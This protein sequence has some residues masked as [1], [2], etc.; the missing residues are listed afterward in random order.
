MASALE[1]DE[2]LC[3]GG[4]ATGA[5]EQRSMGVGSSDR[6][7]DDASVLMGSVKEEGGSLRPAL[8]SATSGAAWGAAG[9]GEGGAAS[10]SAHGACRSSETPDLG[11]GEA[12]VAVGAAAHGA[13]ARAVATHAVG[14]DS[15]QPAPGS[16]SPRGMHTTA[17]AAAHGSAGVA[18]GKE[19]GG[20][21]GGRDDQPQAFGEARGDASAAPL[22]V[23][24][25]AG[26]L[27]KRLDGS[28]AELLGDAQMPLKVLLRCSVDG[29][30]Q[31]GTQQ[32]RGHA[33]C[34]GCMGSL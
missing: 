3:S 12:P 11:R 23:P 18:G 19:D 4:P 5:R 15:R 21:A 1:A 26:Q 16:S 33:T 6:E 28:I 29:E 22:A 34:R 25:K 10:G 32:V 31:P 7:H 17:T 14:E 8:G 9:D 20:R 24:P 27:V 13:S 2:W 30:M